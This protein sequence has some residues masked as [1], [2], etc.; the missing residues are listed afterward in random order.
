MISTKNELK[1]SENLFH[2]AEKICKKVVS[3]PM[4]PYL[5]TEDQ[6]KIIETIK[7]VL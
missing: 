2:N 6:D 5:K 7:D 3:L 1:N 4:Y